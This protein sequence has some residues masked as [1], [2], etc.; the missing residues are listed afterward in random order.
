MHEINH[1][2][3]NLLSLHNHETVIT[4]LE[5]DF[6]PYYWGLIVTLIIRCKKKDRLLICKIY[7][8]KQMIKCIRRNNRKTF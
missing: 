4:N 3:L 1:T 6:G 5:N 7:N 8:S 2:H